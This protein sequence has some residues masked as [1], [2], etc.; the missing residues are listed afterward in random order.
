MLATVSKSVLLLKNRCTKASAL[1]LAIQMM[2]F[3]LLKS[4]VLSNGLSA[5]LADVHHRLVDFCQSDIRR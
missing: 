2:P 1:M 4:L 5:I 3:K